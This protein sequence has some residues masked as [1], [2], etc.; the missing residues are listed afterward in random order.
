MNKEIL[1]LL[2]FE[3]LKNLFKIS[4]SSLSRWE[5]KNQFP[6]RVKFAENSVG[7]RLDEV[8]QWLQERGKI[9]RLEETNK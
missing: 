3:D 5:A 1:T 9:R 8:Q 7:W 4:R 2:R 6:R